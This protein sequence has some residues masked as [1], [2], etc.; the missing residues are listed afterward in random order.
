MRTESESYRNGDGSGPQRVRNGLLPERPAELVVQL[1]VGE[2]EAL[3]R[4]VV[5]DEVTA[6]LEASRESTSRSGTTDELE[7][8]LT[9]SQL[10]DVLNCGVRTLKRWLQEGVAP[11]PL[12]TPGSRL[13]WYMPAVKRWIEQRSRESAERD[14]SLETYDSRSTPGSTRWR[15][16]AD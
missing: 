12:E 16:A 15:K 3:V 10:A 14:V 8:L 1:N 11:P 5:R 6:A 13:R 9:A 4:G 7:Q 2:L